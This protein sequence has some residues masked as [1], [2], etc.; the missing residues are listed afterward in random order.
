MI[1]SVH[2]PRQSCL[3]ESS[4]AQYIATLEEAPKRT[5]STFILTQLRF[6]IFPSLSNVN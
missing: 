1:C 3:A 4:A 5:V 2:N 6:D